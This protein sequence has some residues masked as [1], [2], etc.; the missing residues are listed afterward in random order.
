MN[1]RGVRDSFQ[2]FIFEYDADRPHPDI[3]ADLFKMLKLR[4]QTAAPRR[5][6]KLILLGPP[7]SGKSL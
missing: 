6:P 1:M 3:S 2:Q 4:Y 7:G 5:P